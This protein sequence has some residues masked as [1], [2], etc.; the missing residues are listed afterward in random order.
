MG[1][2]ALLAADEYAH[3]VAA[4]VIDSSSVGLQHLDQHTYDSG[5]RVELAALLAFGARELG[6]KVLVHVAEH[7][8][9]AMG[10]AAVNWLLDMAALWVFLAAYV[11]FAFTTWF[12][13]VRTSFAVRRVP[14]LAYA[15][16]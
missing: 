6:E 11:V 1:L 13:Y 2:D 8:L 12:F 14:S 16:I 5:R 10:W 4:G 7:V 9:R 3:G 15:S